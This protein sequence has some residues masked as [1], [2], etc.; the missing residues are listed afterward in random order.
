M[1]KRP[2][3]SPS[4]L[5]IRSGQTSLTRRAQ[6]R[7]SLGPVALIALGLLL[8]VAAIG[9]SIYIARPAAVSAPDTLAGLPL[10]TASY[11]QSAIAEIARL[12]GKEFPLT[13]GTVAAYGGEAEA[14][15]WVSGAPLSWTASQMVRTM[16]KKIAEGRSPFTPMGTREVSGRT[17]YEL[18]GMGQRHFYFQAGSLVVWLAADET[19]AEQALGDVLTFYR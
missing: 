17:V 12:H 7:A 14:T 6:L 4:A 2:F 19:F 11:G 13:S 8:L 18:T 1:L 9:Y 5:R 15:L 16:E 10:T 3:D